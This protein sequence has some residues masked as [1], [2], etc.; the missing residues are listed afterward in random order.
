MPAPT[1]I[2]REWCA[3]LGVLTAVSI[4]RYEADIK[5]AA[6]TPM[7]A[8]RFPHQVFTPESLEYVAARAIKGFPTY[9]ELAA[10]LAAWWREQRP[11]VALPAPQP[12]PHRQPPTDDER[13]YVRQRVAEITASL[14]RADTDAGL[15]PTR[16]PGPRHLSPA[17]LDVVNP[18]PN[19][20]KRL[21]GASR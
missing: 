2:V 3:S 17:Q 11:F 14:S 20:A 7:L 21:T 8:S 4:S 18:L 1:K 6:Y 19:G 10:W 15:K 16:D 12:E 5:L 13:A 9:P